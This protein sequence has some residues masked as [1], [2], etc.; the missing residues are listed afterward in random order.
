MPGSVEKFEAAL[1]ALCPGWRDERFVLAFS[2]GLDSTALLL[3]ALKIMKPARITAAH[4]N[5]GLRA[6][7]AEADQRFAARISAERGINFITAQEDVAALAKERGKGLEEAARRARY[8][9]LE[10]A[11]REAGAPYILTAHHADDQVETVLMNFIR[12]AGAGGLAGIHP[13]RPL[14]RVTLLRPLLGHS[15][16][17]LKDFVVAEGQSWVE[18]A[19]NQDARY[20][21]NALRLDVIPRLKALNPRL[22]EA[23]SRAGAVLRSEED[24]WQGHLKTLWPQ[25]IAADDESADTITVKRPE[26]EALSLAER[27]RLIYEAFLKIKNRARYAENESGEPLSLATVETVLTMLNFS[28]HKGLDLPGGL[29][30]EVLREELKL[31]PASRFI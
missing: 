25:V 5:H 24:F 22:S 11:A 21:R 2:G 1:A 8:A 29:R 6:E 3:L 14:G 19:S 4:L 26:L 15:R 20:R 28:T 16:E 30:A 23:L 13:R 17:E 10:E 27:R 18:D 12:G 9:F 31:S 7:A